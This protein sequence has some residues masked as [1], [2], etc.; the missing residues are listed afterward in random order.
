MIQSLVLFQPYFYIATK[1]VCMQNIIV[2][3]YSRN[4]QGFIHADGGGGEFSPS[5]PIAECNYIWAVQ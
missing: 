2:L 5:W 3:I 1:K 4:E